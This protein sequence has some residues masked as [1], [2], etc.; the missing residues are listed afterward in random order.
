MTDILLLGISHKTAPVDLRERVAMPYGQASGFLGAL[1]DNDRVQEAVVLSTC[2]RTEVYLVI[3]DPVEAE[4]CVLGMLSRRA[5][6]APTELAE[7]LYSRRDLDAARHLFRVAAGLESMI[8]GETEI[9]S[10]VKRSYEVALEEGMTGLLI[11]RLFR[12]AIA[13][14]KRARHE[15]GVSESRISV[16][17][18]AVELAANVLGNLSE[19]RVLV[20]GAGET[21][22]LTAGALAERG[23]NTVFVANR[24]YD[25][26][27]GLAERFGGTALRFDELPDELEQ[28]DI[29]VSSTASPHTVV[30]HEEMA[31]VMQ[32]REG[33]PLL[34]IDTAVPRDFDPATRSLPGVH[35]YDIDDLQTV[36]EQNISGREA[37]A[38][39]AAAVVEEDLQRFARWLSSLEV[40]PTIAALRELANSIVA[41]ALAE[42]HSKWRA[43]TDEDR[44]RVELMTGAIVNRL[45]HGP[46]VKL[47]QAAAEG[48]GH[49]YVQA[50]RELFGFEL[51]ESGREERKRPV[52]GRS[53][54]RDPGAGT[55]QSRAPEGRRSA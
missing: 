3:S 32:A 17:S 50:L 51:G 20:I 13:A 5:E 28:A 12:E 27:I 35:L 44:E 22:E 46:T 1:V 26:A 15:T 41:Q 45:L 55:P 47:K 2:N 40:V 49:Q 24:H 29:V 19:R 8:V 7:H 34:V 37:E 53:G 4:S 33:R 48:T 9:L 30:D 23:V 38:L 6:I 36:V 21:G 43:M 18:V 39:R 54:D 42:N 31:L 16:S 10:Q 52:T 11:N 14:G 25:R